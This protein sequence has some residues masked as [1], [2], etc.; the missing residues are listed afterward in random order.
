MRTVVSKSPETELEV[1][2]T[3]PLTA[4]PEQVLIEV[5]A[6]GVGRVDLLMRQAIPAQFVPGVEVVGV[7]SQIGDGVDTTLLGRSVFARLSTGGYADQVVASAAHV[8]ALPEHL[9]VE[10]A[11]ASGVN[12]LVAHFALARASLV[13]GDKVLVR[14]AR[15]GIGHLAVQMARSLGG[16]VVAGDVHGST[17]SP[18]VV[19]DLVA[20]PDTSRYLEQLNVNGRYVMA[21]I[22]AGMPSTDFASPLIAGFRRS[23]SVATI[24]LDTISDF[25]LNMAAAQIFADVES[26]RLKPV[27]AREFS[28]AQAQQAHDFLAQGAPLGKIILRP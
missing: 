9:Q 25:E 27:I 10:A 4:G 22:V 24:S 8:V 6:I 1:V 19:V 11:M 18:D 15:G 2:E 28:L 14:G 13:K 23:L 21:G 7:V 20:G 17:T 5:Q 26:G 12:A 16:E 3:L